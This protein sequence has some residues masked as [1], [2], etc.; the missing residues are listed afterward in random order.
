ML[1]SFQELRELHEQLAQHQVHIEMDMTKPDL[2]AAL[3]EIRIQYESMATNNMHE[4]EEWYKSKV[5]LPKV[6][7]I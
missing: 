4:T 2:T 7:A 5:T 1:V 3:R 6:K